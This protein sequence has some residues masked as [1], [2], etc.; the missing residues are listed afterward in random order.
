MEENL[1]RLI[2]DE[3]EKSS[4]PGQEQQYH[5]FGQDSLVS[6]ITDRIINSKE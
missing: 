5:R 4:A 1:G 2:E 6:R 3:I